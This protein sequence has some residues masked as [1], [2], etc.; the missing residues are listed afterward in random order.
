MPRKPGR[1]GERAAQ[2]EQGVL[3]R[4]TIAIHFMRMHR[5]HNYL[6]TLATEHPSAY[7]SLVTKTVPQT[8][9]L[10]VA[11]EHTVDLGQ[12]MLEA[13]QRLAAAQATLNLIDVTPATSDLAPATSDVV[14]DTSDV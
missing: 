1:T 10:D 13:S 5:D 2:H 9:R 12:A 8:A 4:D 14:R 11:V 3:V 6:N 7:V